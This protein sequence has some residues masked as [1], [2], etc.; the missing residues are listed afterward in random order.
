MTAGT[1]R[2]PH[3]YRISRKEAERSGPALKEANR[4]ERPA[5]FIIQRRHQFS[6]RQIAAIAGAVMVEAAVIYVVATGLTFSGIRAIPHT[7]EAEVLKVVPPKV[8]PVVVPQTQL[9]KP[10]PAAVPPPEIQIQ[11]PQPP[12]QIT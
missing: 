8:Q 1:I 10:A 3:R 7:V 6:P 2:S 11:T 5:H 4:M 9:V 12:P